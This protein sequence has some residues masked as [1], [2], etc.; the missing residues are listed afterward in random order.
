M[1]R[2]LI[3]GAGSF[4]AL[5]VLALLSPDARAAVTGTD[6]GER[7]PAG[8]DYRSC[9][10]AD[11]TAVRALIRAV[12][13]ERIL[14]LAGT[15]SRDAD[16]CYRVN[17]DGTRNV[18]EA[19]AALDT[20]PRLLVISSSAVYGLSRPEES[21]LREETPLRP[22]AAYGA[23][24]A[25]AEIAVLSFH[26]AGRLAVTVARPFNLIGPGLRAG[27]APA[28]FLARIAAIRRGET[29]PVLRTG[30]L[31]PR[32]D[33][34]DGRDAARAYL[35]LLD[36]ADLAGGVFNIAG[37]RAVAMGDLLQAILAACGVTAAVEE[38]PALMRP[39]EVIEQV[40]D[41]S[42]LRSAIGWIPVYR[43]EDSVRDMATRS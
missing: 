41:A 42:A 23:S 40:G 20:P 28:D 10:L 12:R 39:V 7:G 13:P 16:V 11:R 33:Y 30:N 43:L 9:D 34:V 19:A 25:A 5:H 2:L 14:H 29:P 24:K 4:T 31:T 21:P 27:L 3:T 6:L 36:R 17:L 37:G 26:R 15:D 35:G 1:P 38:D 8:I 32:R 22:L 18:L